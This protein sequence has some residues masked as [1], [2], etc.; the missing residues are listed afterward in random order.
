M[1]LAVEREIYI[2][3]TSAYPEWTENQKKRGLDPLGMQNSSIDLYQRLLP[4]IGNVT[5]RMRYYG[6]YAWL[7]WVY[8]KKIGHTDPQR[9]QTFIRRAE[10]LYAL[11]AVDSG[12]EKGMAGVEW[13]DEKLRKT[14]EGM[15]NFYEA[16][17]PG[18]EEN[19][20]RQAWGVYGLAYKSQMI[21]IGILIPS[22][23]HETPIASKASGE[24]LAHAISDE[25]GDVIERFFHF[26]ELGK[27]M[28]EDLKSMASLL[29]SAIG[30]SSKER[31]LYE[32]LL[33]AKIEP[34]NHSHQERRNTLLQILSIAKYLQATPRHDEVRWALYSTC[35][36]AGEAL[37]LKNK[38]LERSRTAWKIYHANDLLH[39]SYETL[40][41]HTL[42]VVS[43][44]PEGIRLPELVS[45][46]V[47]GVMRVQD[48]CPQTWGNFADKIGISK[49]PWSADDENNELKLSMTIDRATKTDTYKTPPGVA[50]M[51][52]KLLAILHN[53]MRTEFKSDELKKKFGALN[54]VAFRSLLTEYRFFEEVVGE[55][56]QSM[57]IRLFEERII[58]RHLWVAS[59][60]FRHQGDY[61]FLME[62]DD[63]RLKLRGTDKPVFTNPRL[64]P[65]ITFL[66]DIHLLDEQGLTDL[67]LK[68]YEAA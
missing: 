60:K 39:F 16:T 30:R 50:L 65:A 22:T 66:K 53:R 57:L 48:N 14:P 42:D 12:N 8:A 59:K 29:P 56:L 64:T 37:L 38:G 10:A 27:V 32:K 6:L 23:E 9:W 31:E 1:D 21:E 46:V 47:T 52:L 2:V 17:D 54:D 19:Y 43:E 34:D 55:P 49:N 18:G 4:G 7:V 26:I 41:R 28:R 36:K 40:L 24:P 11:I 20:F 33:F 68:I 67:G 5:N 58:K 63:G 45:E 25:M 13:A 62:V 3:K 51:A 35:G 15:I 61:T 44:H